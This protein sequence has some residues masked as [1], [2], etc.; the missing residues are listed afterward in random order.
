MTI[1]VIKSEQYGLINKFY[2]KMLENGIW[3]IV[4]LLIRKKMKK[5]FSDFYEYNYGD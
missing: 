4:D 3:I 2:Q 1:Y 5:I